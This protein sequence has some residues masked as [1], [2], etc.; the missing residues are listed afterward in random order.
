MEINF[1]IE[2]ILYLFTQREIREIEVLKQM[3]TI[4]FNC[5]IKKINQIVYRAE[6]S[7]LNFKTRTYNTVWLGWLHFHHSLNYLIMK[8]E[9]ENSS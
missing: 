3:A 4:Y 9:T 8:I 1:K 2:N 5:V 6:Q 7:E